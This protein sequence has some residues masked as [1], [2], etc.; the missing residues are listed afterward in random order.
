MPPEISARQRNNLLQCISEQL[1]AGRGD[2][3]EAACVEL[4][5]AQPGDA[6]ALW[7]AGIAAQ[8][9]G[10]PALAA[11]RMGSVITQRNAD[12]GDWIRYGSLLAACRL[13]GAATALDHALSLD[14]DNPEALLQ[15]AQLDYAGDDF[16]AALPLARRLVQLTP[17]AVS[18]TL[19]LAKVL[20]G[21]RQLE[22]AEHCYQRVLRQAGEQPQIQFEYAMQRLLTG[23]FADGWRYYDARLSYDIA[24]TASYPFP[25]PLWQGQSLTG[26][27]LLVHGEQGLGDEVMF[28]SLL[29][30]L[31]S[32]AAQ[33]VIAVSP[34]LLELFSRSFPAAQ[35][36]PMDRSPEAITAWRCGWQ[37]GWLAGL[38]TMDYQSP[39]G[40]LPRWRRQGT[41]DFADPQ[42]YLLANSRRSE[43]FRRQI[44][45]RFASKK[46]IIGLA[47]MG[48]QATGAMGL[49]KSI[50]LP[51]L[52]PLT[53]LEHCCFVSLH[54]PPHTQTLEQAPEG[55]R[56]LDF[57]T[58]L[59]TLD[60]TA[61]LISACDLVIS[62][63][64]VTAHLAAALG[65]PTWVPLRR[66]ADWRYL[67]N[68]DRALW[69]PQMRL[70]RQQQEG[71][72]Q[73]VIEALC[74]RLEEEFTDTTG[75][76]P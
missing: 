53:A 52:A 12:A 39:V 49:G 75:T 1:S 56:I 29:P 47:W 17:T 66:A 21:L 27:S 64:T 74:K 20:H 44:Q 23:H 33:V 48:N 70:F 7:L 37:P 28:A 42:P 19:F 8:M 38:E 11:A 76:A 63:D 26:K 57:S 67:E 62:V 32:T 24:T 58:R 15:R 14:P 9:R 10:L 6:D 43:G 68:T 16:A 54:I 2:D 50:A 25:Q 55:M 13:P 34:T 60:D 18:S 4:L 31:I 30:E 59:K 35:V 61:A 73:P 3:A 72:W 65:L 45:S 51:L 5:S 46:I 41:E 22:E 36:L 69:Y 71:Q 40:S